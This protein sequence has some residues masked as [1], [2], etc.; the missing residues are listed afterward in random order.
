MI[1]EFKQTDLNEVMQLWMD[2]NIQSHNFISKKYW[3]ENYENVKELLPQS[4]LYVFQDV[5]SN[6]IEGFIGLTNNYIAGI[7][8]RADMQSKGIG[9]QLIDYIKQFK[10]ELSLSVFQKNKQAVSFY[11]REE[12][13]IQSE[14]IDE[15]TNENELIMT[16]KQ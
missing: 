6:R 3:I 13:I 7:F 14:N 11:Q 16:W 15:H 9:K 1:R 12:F 4:D 2:T 10:S 8:V 5:E